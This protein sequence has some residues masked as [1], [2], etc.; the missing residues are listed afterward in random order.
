MLVFAAEAAGD[1]GAGKAVAQKWCGKCHVV[2]LD[3]PYAGIDSTPS[4]LTFARKPGTYPPG[5]IRSF[6]ERPPH[7][8]FEFK[9]SDREMA[10]LIAYIGT[11]KPE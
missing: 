11:L 2:S 6:S 5:R 9:V 3:D 8:Q 1:A 10:D 4:F 7:P